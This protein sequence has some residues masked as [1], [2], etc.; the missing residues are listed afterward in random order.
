MLHTEYVRDI[1][2]NYLVIKGIE[3]YTCGYRTKILLNNTIEGVLKV[4]LKFIDQM[5]LFYYNINNKKSLSAA[6]ENKSLQYDDIKKLLRSILKIINGSGDYLLSE[7]DFIIDPE[8]IFVEDNLEMVYLCYLEGYQTNMLTQFSKLMEYLMNKVDYKDENAVVLTY[9]L[10][11]ESREEDCTYE[12][13]MNE[14]EKKISLQGE[15]SDIRNEDQKGKADINYNNILQDKDIGKYNDHSTNNYE[16]PNQYKDAKTNKSGKKNVGVKQSIDNKYSKD[17]KTGKDKNKNYIN[18]NRASQ[19]HGNSDSGLKRDKL[20]ST[21]KQVKD[22]GKNTIRE[23][24]C[25]SPILTSLFGSMQQKTEK[26]KIKNN[27][28]NNDNK[29]PGTKE[30]NKYLQTRNGTIQGNDYPFIEEIQSDKEVLVYEKKTYVMA[31]GAVLLGFILLLI[32]AHLKLLHNAFG[33]QIDIIKLIGCLLI[34]C[35]VE[36]Y[37]F[38]KLF[39]PNNRI[40]KMVSSVDYV[41]PNLEEMKNNQLYIDKQ[42]NIDIETQSEVKP[43]REKEEQLSLAAQS[44]SDIIA[45]SDLWME[46]GNGQGSKDNLDGGQEDTVVLWKEDE[47]DSEMTKILADLTPR[48]QYYLESCDI[49][50]ATTRD[51]TSN[52]ISSTVI[53]VMEFP[54]IVGKLAT[55]VNHRIQNQTVS[56]RHAKFMKEKEDIY[57][58]D[59]GSTNGTFLNG[60]RLTN[61]KLYKLTNNDE[62]LIAQNK[63]YWKIK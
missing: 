42:G 46:R 24:V 54:F 52:T 2:N 23:L 9:G 13:L 5:D 7:N 62:I 3:D 30:N 49:T 63:F 58:I 16:D 35:S 45:E 27:G 38:S 41:E 43:I 33:T 37:I 31:L 22:N 14:L 50:H 6:Y 61:H 10:Y 60:I 56:R 8:Y 36:I 4:E 21:K 55:G 39:S 17:N 57:L 48:K 51:I 12:R 40:T 28:I 1:H 26:E 59:L 18:Q 29:I 32:I 34:I 19:N 47:K 20:G 25:N 53:P 11:K 15:K 44:H